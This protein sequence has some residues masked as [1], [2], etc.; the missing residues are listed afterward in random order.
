M[1]I[2]NYPDRIFDTQI[3]TKKIFVPMKHKF[4][5]RKDVDKNG[6]SLIYLKLTMKGDLKRI[7][8][9]LYAQ[10]SNWSP[11]KQRMID[12]SPESK[13][14]NLVLDNIE[15]KITHIKTSFR[16]SEIVLTLEAF[17]SEF[18]NGMPRIDFIAFFKNE[19]ENQKAIKHPN[20]IKKQTSVYRALKE[21]KPKILFSEID[22]MLL[23]RFKSFRSK[24]G[25]GKNTINSNMAVIK[26]YINIAIDAGIKMPLTSRQ[27]KVGS[28]NGNRESLTPIELNKLRG[29]YESNFVRDN[30]KLPLAMFIFSCFTGLRIS[31]AQQIEE[32][33]I[34][35]KYLKFTS[36]KTG[37]NQKIR[38]P[39]AAEQII[40]T[41]PEIFTHDHTD[42]HINRILKDICKL[43]G[44]KK[45]V[46]FHYARHTFATNYL[47][48]GGK[49][50]V[51]QQMLGHSN[52]KETMIYVTILQEQQDEAML[53]LD[54]IKVT[55]E[56]RF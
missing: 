37:K 41:C 14:F 11:L 40:D 18:R 54:N 51:L 29:Y 35:D 53:L 28:T 23:E 4:F 1:R 30:H 21:F 17:E 47:R 2:L 31:D 3:D 32:R 24:N 13:D 45:N 42:Q 9:D 55:K 10:K 12:N 26:K 34:T 25:C 8:L 16:L 19:L 7:S 27:I 39:E 48:M 52:I 44:I 36:I 46:T 56:T 38:L 33:F 43:V 20:T 6:K 50:E 49:V 22:L 15:S 5:L